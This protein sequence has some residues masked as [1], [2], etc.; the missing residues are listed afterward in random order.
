MGHD[1]LYVAYN[2]FN[3]HIFKATGG[4][5]SE[6]QRTIYLSKTCQI[7]QTAQ[8][9]ARFSRKSETKVKDKVI[10]F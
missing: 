8:Q 6:G 3:E 10:M 1:T 4:G 7:T 5:G 2:M 9:K